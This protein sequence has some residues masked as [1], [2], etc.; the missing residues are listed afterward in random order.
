MLLN[1]GA[2]D[3][4]DIKSTMLQLIQAHSTMQKAATATFNA[5]LADVKIEL[6]ENTLMLNTKHPIDP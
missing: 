5:S 1:E 3:C 4:E 2:T 6:N